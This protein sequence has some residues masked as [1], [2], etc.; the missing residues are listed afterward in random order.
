MPH[1]F[2][3]LDTKCGFRVNPAYEALGPVDRPEDQTLR[4]IHWPYVIAL[5]LIVAGI[6]IKLDH[7][8]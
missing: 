7:V 5:I 4:S 1:K 2:F 8:F 3:G 6:A